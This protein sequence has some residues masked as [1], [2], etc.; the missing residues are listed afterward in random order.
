[1]KNDF[2][3]WR[4]TITIP[5]MILLFVAAVSVGIIIF[6]LLTG[7]GMVTNLSDSHPWG[8]WIAFDVLAGVALAGGGYSTALIVH[9]LHQGKYLSVA[10][11]A[12]LT[13]LFGYILVMVGLFLDIG[14][15][16]NFWRPFVSWGHSSVLFEVFWCLSIY[17][18]IQ[19]LEFGEIVTE[20][21]G[22]KF[23]GWIKKML[24][25]L[26]IVGVIFPTLHQSSLGG[27]FLI[28][29]YKLYP[30]W[31][32]SYIPVFFLLSS[33]F[34]GPA[35]ICVESII[36]GRAFRHEISTSVLHG[37]AKISSYAMMVYLLLKV[38][39]LADRE[40]VG[41][42][43]AG[44][45]EGNVFLIEMIVGIILPI[46]IVFSKVGA[47]KKGLLSYGLLVSCGV[48]LNRLNIVFIGMSKPGQGAYFPSI[49]EI[50]TS[51]GLV[52]IG[53]LAYCFIVENFRIFE[54]DKQ[55]KTY[56]KHSA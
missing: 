12:L 25:V 37:L 8:F 13:S 11:S 28:A 34:V 53:C 40:M 45:M 38:Y 21:I 41:L 29:V 46:G 44:N 23:H 2:S 26:I 1:M 6:R 31:W 15:W 5:R 17:T 27:L 52:A 33:F 54:Q 32:S 30:L 18:T 20:R 51:M 56:Y 47:T 3:A 7:F 43:F 42:L 48:V 24:P 39:D 4:F 50:L 49:W 10:R 35:M 19:V 22:V 36:A 14:Q 16:F 9:V 55:Q